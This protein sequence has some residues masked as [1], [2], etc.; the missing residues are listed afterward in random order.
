MNN[1]DKIPTGKKQQDITPEEPWCKRPNLCETVGPAATQT[2]AS[3]KCLQ[4]LNLTT[5]TPFL[6]PHETSPT[7]QTWKMNNIITSQTAAKRDISWIHLQKRFDTELLLWAVNKRQALSRRPALMQRYEEESIEV[8]GKK[9]FTVWALIWHYYPGWHS[10]NK[11]QK[12]REKEWVR[13]AERDVMMGQ[14]KVKKTLMR[15]RKWD[16]SQQ[17]ITAGNWLL[18][19]AFSLRKLFEPVFQNLPISFI[20]LVK[21]SQENEFWTWEAELRGWILRSLFNTA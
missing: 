9:T 11:E 12:E 15:E 3:V 14:M 13:E 4:Q 17:H 20:K 8:E 2:T 6:H 21:F 18:P 16:G 1:C 7:L 19:E 10:M 5:T